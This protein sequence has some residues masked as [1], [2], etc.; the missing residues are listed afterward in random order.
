VNRDHP[1]HTVR[2][3]DVDAQSRCAHWHSAIDIVAMRFKCC[4]DYYAC[5]DCHVALAGHDVV[6]WAADDQAEHVA[7]CG[8]CGLEMTMGEYLAVNDDRC[9]RCTAAFNPGCRSHRHFYFEP[10]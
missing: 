3:I 9:P 8:V 5:H 4:G 7:M 6:R 10:T 2:G 1:S